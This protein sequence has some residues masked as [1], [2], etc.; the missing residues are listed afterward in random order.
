MNDYKDY[1]EKCWR[2][3]N[4]RPKPRPIESSKVFA[5]IKPEDYARN[6]LYDNEK[7]RINE[8]ANTPSVAC[9]GF[10]RKLLRHVL[11][12]GMPPNTPLGSACVAFA[13][14]ALEASEFSRP[15]YWSENHYPETTCGGNDDHSDYFDY[16]ECVRDHLDQS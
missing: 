1:L 4:K 9:T 5:D 14:Y 8:L 7:I 16:I 6:W 13:K 10:E 2:E 12:S 11:F 15:N 3:I